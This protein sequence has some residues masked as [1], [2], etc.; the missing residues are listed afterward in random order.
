MKARYLCCGLVFTG[1]WV[2]PIQ[3]SIKQSLFTALD[4]TTSRQFQQT[5]RFS[6]T[7]TNDR[8]LA[9]D[10]ANH[11]L[12]SLMLSSATFLGF[13]ATN[14][15]HEQSLVAAIGGTILIGVGKEIWDMYH[16]GT[17][18]WKDLTADALGAL[19]GGLVARAIP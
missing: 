7:W 14:N 6:M 15:N 13:A 18:S 2:S 11:F 12:G 8:W 3:A 4:D 19:I 10:K 1:L 9:P 5:C 17:P 16:P